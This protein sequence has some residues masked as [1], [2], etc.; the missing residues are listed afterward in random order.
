M[1]VNRILST[2]FSIIFFFQVLPVLTFSCIEDCSGQ[3]LFLRYSDLSAMP[4]E[5]IPSNPG[6]RVDEWSN[7]K[8]L[9]TGKLLIMFDLTYE[10]I[11]EV[12]QTTSTSGLPFAF[13]CDPAVN[14][15]SPV[16]TWELH[17]NKNF[18]DNYPAGALLNDIVLIAPRIGGQFFPFS[19]YLD[20]ISGNRGLGTSFV[21]FSELST[22]TSPFDLTCTITLEDGRVFSNTVENIV[23]R[24][25]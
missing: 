13:A 5:Y 17:S 12:K 20:P 8:N 3:A 10:S 25:E 23:L 2:I 11:A 19:E 7:Q 1:R 16:K 9:T 14:F 4:L 15:E 24:V 22:Q 18:N 6:W 21:R